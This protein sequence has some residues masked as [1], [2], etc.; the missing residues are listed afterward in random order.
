MGHKDWMRSG[1]ILPMPE[2]STDL[3]RRYSAARLIESF[4]HKSPLAAVFIKP[5]GACGGPPHLFKM[6]G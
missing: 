4:R 3:G 6:I 1:H 5:A 2:I